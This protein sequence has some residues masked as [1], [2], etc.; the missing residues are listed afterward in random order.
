MISLA[1]ADLRILRKGSSN[2]KKEPRFAK[3]GRNDQ[4]INLREE[5]EVVAD[6]YIF[7]KGEFKLKIRVKI[8]N[9]TF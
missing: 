3:T 7:K 5:V 8:G 1:E 6:F 9:S 2:K 4:S